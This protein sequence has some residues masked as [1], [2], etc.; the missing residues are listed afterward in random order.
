ML[1]G[2]VIVLE[3]NTE[4]SI[5]QISYENASMLLI[6]VI[7]NFAAI[8]LWGTLISVAIATVI[9]V[10]I[11]YVVNEIKLK[12]IVAQTNQQIMKSI[13]IIICYVGTFW[14]SFLL[15]DVIILKNIL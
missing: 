6:S 5:V 2:A 9:S 10:M 13:G 15:S 1:D 14:L 4:S 11:W 7:L 12:Q 3:Y 8:K